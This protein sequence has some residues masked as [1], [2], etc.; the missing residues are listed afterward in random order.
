MEKAKD[1]K[2]YATYYM[3]IEN[4]EKLEENE[5]KTGAKKSAVVN[6]ALREFFKRKSKG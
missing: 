5:R 3:E 1:T 2:K 4:I 6:M